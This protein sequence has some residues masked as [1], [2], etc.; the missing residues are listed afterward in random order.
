MIYSINDRKFSPRKIK[1]FS[2]FFFDTMHHHI[3][4][5]IDNEPD[6]Y[7]L[8]VKRLDA[9]VYAYTSD[10]DLFLFDKQFEKQQKIESCEAISRKI[11]AM[12][13]SE[14]LLYISKI[15]GVGDKAKDIKVFIKDHEDIDRTTLIVNLHCSMT[16]DIVADKNPTIL[17]LKNKK[18]HKENGGNPF[19][20]DSELN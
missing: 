11:G 2:K 9:V 7:A 4:K 14:L 6:D 12:D 10:E 18:T 17:S 19:E 3:Q 1:K 15:V 13:R 8:L 5:V 20:N 16:V